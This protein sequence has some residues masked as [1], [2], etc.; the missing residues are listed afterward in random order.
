M[1]NKEMTCNLCGNSATV[2]CNW[3]IR[4]RICVWFYF[5]KL[6]SNKCFYISL[7][8]SF[9]LFT[10][11]GGEGVGAVAEIR[12]LKAFLL[13]SPELLQFQF[14]QSANEWKGETQVKENNE[15]L[16]GATGKVKS[17]CEFH[18]VETRQW[19]INE[20]METGIPL[21]TVIRLLKTT[22]IMIACS[23][24]YFNLE[25]LSYWFCRR[26]RS[27]KSGRITENI[28]VGMLDMES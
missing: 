13:L 7:H 20:G 8:S 3:V 27:R 1:L 5:A 23:N 14:L 18:R 28:F 15:P 24:S 2:F 25:N 21:A 19:S 11:W 12:S 4:W 22:I 6:L 9:L 10:T 16:K 26:D 17:P